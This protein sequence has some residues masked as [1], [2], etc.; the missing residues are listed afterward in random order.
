MCS[1]RSEESGS[2]EEAAG[3]DDSEDEELTCENVEKILDT[4]EDP[5]HGEQFHVKFRGERGPVQQTGVL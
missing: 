2:E 5:K 1:I 4:R 3:S